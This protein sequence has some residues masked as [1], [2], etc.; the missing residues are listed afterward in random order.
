MEREKGGHDFYREAAAKT[1]DPKGKSMF[2]WLAKQEM[3]HY[4]KLSSQREALAQGKVWQEPSETA[5]PALG[6]SEFPQ[7][8][9]ASGE[10]RVN[11]GELDALKV[12][13]EA[14][15]ESIALYRQAAQDSTN[16]D[17]KEMFLR[18]V[19]EEEGHLELLEN[20]FEW[21]RRSGAYFTIHRFSLKAQ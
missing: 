3:N 20:E 5:E 14:E 8:S 6:R 11:T 7:I 12:G 21:L 17:A 15:K 10:V 19:A 13:I 4:Q 1:S 9:E 16:E 2:E 18:L